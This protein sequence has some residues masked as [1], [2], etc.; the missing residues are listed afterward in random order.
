MYRVELK[1]INGWVYI[2]TFS[3]W[4]DCFKFLNCDISDDTDISIY[5]TREELIYNNLGKYFNIKQLRN[6]V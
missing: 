1:K 2:Q 6:I 4:E 5:K 3:S